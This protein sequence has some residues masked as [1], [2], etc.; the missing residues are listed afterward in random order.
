[1]TRA[2]MALQIIEMI[3][4]R[5]PE[6]SHSQECARLALKSDSEIEMLYKKLKPKK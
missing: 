3:V 1:M 4:K 6:A 5:L 2:E